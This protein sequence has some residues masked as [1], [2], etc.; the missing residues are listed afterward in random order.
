MNY[1]SYN[2]QFGFLKPTHMLHG[3]F[4]SLIDQYTKILHFDASVKDPLL[5]ICRQRE[6]ALRV[7]VHRLEYRRQQEERE[8]R[9]KQATEEVLASQ[10]V[11]WEDFVVVETITFEDE[12]SSRPLAASLQP[13]GLCASL[14]PS[15]SRWRWTWTPR[16]LL[17][18]LLHLLHLPPLPLPPHRRDSAWSTTTSPS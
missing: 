4:L 11:D 12:D 6:A 15:R 10:T 9:Q 16:P 3:F 8:R 18:L 7:S 17:H 13:V 5:D 14:D 2:P 1:Q